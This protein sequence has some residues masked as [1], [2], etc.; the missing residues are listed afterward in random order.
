MFNEEVMFLLEEFNEQTTKTINHYS[1]ELVKV[2]AGRAN[3]KMIEQIKVDYYGTAT[4]LFQMANISVPDPRQLLISPYDMSMVKA[5]LKA[6]DAAN[7]GL[8]PSDDG[9]AIRLNFPPLTE[10][11]RRD[12]VK[13]IAKLNEASKVAC[14]NHRRDT[15]DEVKRMKKDSEITEDDLERIEKEVQKRLDANIAKIDAMHANKEKE[16]MEV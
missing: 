10:E 16:L 12:M 7:L 11:R 13:E 1:D 14:R 2:R 3:P 4:P 8:T 5:V 15:L 9:R 6:I